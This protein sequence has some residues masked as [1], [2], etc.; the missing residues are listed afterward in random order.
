M[1]IDKEAHFY[2]FL[3]EG[4]IVCDLQAKNSGDAISILARR[5]Q[6]TTAGVFADA[7]V[8]AVL[9]REKIMPTVIAPG[10][11]V[12]HARIDGLDRLV[13]ALGISKEGVDFATPPMPPANVIVLILSPKDKPAIHLKV[14][15]ALAKDLKDPASIA[16][17]A[18]LNSPQD[19][20]RFFCM[21]GNPLPP[22]LVARDLLEPNVVTLS[23]S[24][25]LQKAIATLATKRVM[26]IPIV[27]DEG[28]V[29]GVV[30]LEDILRHSL[31]EHMLWMDDLSPIL[32][33]QPFAE[34]LKKENGTKIADFMREEFISVDENVPAIQLAKIFLVNKIRQIIVTK[35][36]KFAGVVEINSFVSNVFWA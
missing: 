13:V 35:D 27:D 9:E 29:R 16:K 7:V 26:D 31:P 30:S 19:A 3:A 36:A 33:F 2:H 6:A 24:D 12:P 14:I 22:Y 4:N 21:N 23:E 11:A 8:E 25:T 5:L 34:T 32:N 20:M 18:Q 10:L 28:D 15:S 17:L 1:N